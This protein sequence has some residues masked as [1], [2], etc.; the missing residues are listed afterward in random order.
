MTGTCHL[1]LNS[2]SHLSKL[3]SPSF[4]MYCS[5]LY[6]YGSYTERES[7][8][9]RGSDLGPVNAFRGSMNLQNICIFTHDFANIFSELA[10]DS[11][12]VYDPFS[13][14]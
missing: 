12:E 6:V 11:Q 8:Q 4:S 2:F 10:S 9:I 14:V 3:L 7:V 1:L 5:E 13:L